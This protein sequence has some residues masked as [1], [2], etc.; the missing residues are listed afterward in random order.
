[1]KRT[2]LILAAALLASGCEALGGK[3]EAAVA[4]APTEPKTLELAVPVQVPADKAKATGTYIDAPAV[5]KVAEEAGCKIDEL[6]F[7]HLDGKGANIVIKCGEQK[8]LLDVTE[9][10]K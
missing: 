5:I 10:M 9:S 2:G 3:Q 8:D 1:M 6:A 7:R 4:P